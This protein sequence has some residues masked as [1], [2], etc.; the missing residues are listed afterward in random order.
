MY[1]IQTKERT[2]VTSQSGDSSR[3][4]IQG[5]YI[6][7]WGNYGIYIYNIQTKETKILS[8]SGHFYDP[9]VYGDKV[10]W[11]EA[12][13]VIGTYVYDVYMY[14]ISTDQVVPLTEIDDRSHSEPAIFEDRVVWSQYENDSYKLYM[15]EISSKKTTLIHSSK[16]YFSGISF[17]GNR[18]YY[19]K[20]SNRM[21]H[22]YEYDLQ[23]KQERLITSY[24]STAIKYLKANDDKLVWHWGG[25]AFLYDLKTGA[26]IQLSEK[27]YFPVF[28]NNIVA[29]VDLRNG[30]PNIYYNTY[31]SLITPT[32]QS[33]SPKNQ[34]NWYRSDVSVTLTP[35][36]PT[37]IE[38]TEYR[39]NSGEW[40]E[41]KAPFTVSTEGQNL[42]QYRSTID[43]TIEDFIHTLRV[44][45][46]KTAPTLQVETTRTTL[47]RNNLLVPIQMKVTTEDP[48]SGVSSW[49]LSSIKSNELIMPN[50]I[51]G[52]QYNTS[53]LTFFLR[54][55]SKTR[56]GR[57]Y[58]IT[59]KATDLAGN[60]V[61]ATKR[62]Y[63]PF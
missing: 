8:R 54:A 52:A 3:P 19:L 39:V 55:I 43:G 62:I 60:Q 22:V 10:V 12:R 56:Y 14:D 9:K 1:D 13:N 42:V 47:L 63:V 44:N 30:N 11:D 48:N 61:T 37:N 4:V 31:K 32:L 41:Y 16:D 50:D 57:F 21:Y 28:D 24:P 27:S 2:R 18:I 53:D 5:N 15:Y 26:E 23:S 25:R 45:I 33:S 40:T 49:V 20:S 38:K 46:D 36:D 34:N 6:V 59:Y 7:W 17:F 58:L 29:W 51:Q 35:D